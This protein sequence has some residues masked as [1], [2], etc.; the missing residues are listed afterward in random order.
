MTLLL[1][2]RGVVVAGGEEVEA[3]LLGAHGVAHQ[4]L[5]PGLLSHDRVPERHR[6]HLLVQLAS[7]AA[8]PAL[9]SPTPHCKERPLPLTAT[10]NRGGRED[11]SLS[12]K[13]KITGAGLAAMLAT[14]GASMS[15]A[16]VGATPARPPAV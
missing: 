15:A 1:E 3:G 13:S 7:S 4:L 16:G 11:D 2:P 9:R 5:G 12:L 14:A 6:R 10:T 8:Y